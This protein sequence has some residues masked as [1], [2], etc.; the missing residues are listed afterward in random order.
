MGYLVHDSLVLRNKC[1]ELKGKRRTK[2]SSKNLGPLISGSRSWK[3]H[4]LLFSFFCL[5]VI[6][7]AQKRPLRGL[8]ICKFVTNS[9]V[10]KSICPPLFP[11]T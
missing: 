10:N 3:C 5:V 2:E 6:R 7:E 1:P 4:Y 9:V 8:R 11:V